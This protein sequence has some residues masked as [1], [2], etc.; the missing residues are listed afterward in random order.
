MN[1]FGHAV[2]AS[3][4]R[5]EVAYVFG[6][7]LPDFASMIGAR[8]PPIGDADV[9]AGAQD[10]HVIDELFHELS[11]F[12]TLC[13]QLGA[14][15]IALGFDRG[16]AR[17]VAHVGVEILLDRPLG[18]DPRARGLYSAALDQAGPGGLGRHLAWSTAERLRF[19]RLRMAL[20]ARRNAATVDER[21]TV[22]F[23]LER[24]LERRPRLALSHEQCDKVAI[25][26]LHAESAVSSG[27]AAL[28]AEL[29]AG[30]D[31]CKLTS[32]PV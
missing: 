10:H 18:D 30:L 27:A 11:T 31:A 26:L 2:V 6:S 9:M 1:F 23:R 20:E 29:K 16:R 22:V 15:L 25:W 32:A 4:L 28:V 19:E 3:W 12:R 8:V 13:H 14:K 24:A 21:A 17:A 7:M 5:P